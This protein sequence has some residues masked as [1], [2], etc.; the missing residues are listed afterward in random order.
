MSTA[1]VSNTTGT[2]TGKDPKSKFSIFCDRLAILQEDMP[3]F[4]D[5]GAL[6]LI[7]ANSASGW[8]ESFLPLG[9]E[10]ILSLLRIAKKGEVFTDNIETKDYLDRM[11]HIL[12]S[13]YDVLYM[14]PKMFGGICQ[15]ILGRRRTGLAFERKCAAAYSKAAFAVFTSKIL[16]IE[17]RLNDILNAGQRFTD[18]ANK[19]TFI[20][21]CLSNVNPKG[22]DNNREKARVA[23][24]SG[25]NDV[26]IFVSEFFD[27]LYGI[28]T[29]DE[30]VSDS[31]G[32]KLE[33]LRRIR[34][35]DDNLAAAKPGSAR[36]EDN[37]ASG[38]G[39]GV[40]VNNSVAS[41][42]RIK[43]L[44][45]CQSSLQEIMNT[46]MSKCRPII[47]ENLRLLQ[48]IEKLVN[49]SFSVFKQRLKESEDP[50]DP[51]KVKDEINRY[52]EEV[53]QRHSDLTSYIVE[54][55]SRWDGITNQCVMRPV[56]TFVDDTP[57]PVVA[58]TNIIDIDP[59]KQTGKAIGNIG[60]KGVSLV[61]EGAQN[62][63]EGAMNVGN[64]AKELIFGDDSDNFM[65]GGNSKGSH[66]NNYNNNNSSQSKTTTTPS[67]KPQ[68][69]V[70]S[71]ST[72]AGGFTN[73]GGK[74][75]GTAKRLEF[76]S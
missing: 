50:N 18:I 71:N 74:G 69:L 41:N 9:R 10:L 2:G 45:K 72:A 49:E 21:K 34:I 25:C 58:H 7:Q 16:L 28:V 65:G 19:A 33:A 29:T 42:N 63:K 54:A 40:P 38:H 31:N 36:N 15:C 67:N 32:T 68:N 20:F 43:L 26:H 60:G 11:A 14:P 27:E 57:P 23:L 56:A 39:R 37:S 76:D 75:T 73:N 62:I 61:K 64:I 6:T 30:K 48:A 4:E 24:Q 35:A 13:Y 53:A 1:I 17:G 22:N 51:V 55:N 46:A 66:N 8:L 44:V 3:A 5:N 70:K 59:L 12:E 52:S 47:L